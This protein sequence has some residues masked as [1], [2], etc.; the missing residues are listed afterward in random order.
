MITY[1][2]SSRWGNRRLLLDTRRIT[3]EAD[4]HDENS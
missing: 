3:K 4:K 1:M 2:G